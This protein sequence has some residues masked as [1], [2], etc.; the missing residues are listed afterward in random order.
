MTPTE[1]HRETADDVYDNLARGHDLDGVSRHDVVLAFAF[2]IARAEREG[3]KRA[4]EKATEHAR[5]LR[6]VYANDCARAIEALRD[7]LL[8]E[9][10]EG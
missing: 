7:E 2:A 4:A 3:M 8:S 5:E 1:K 6:K 10:G 9:A